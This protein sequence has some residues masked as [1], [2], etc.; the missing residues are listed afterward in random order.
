MVEIDNM[1]FGYNGELLFND[2]SLR[3]EKGNIYGLLGLNG[4][5]KTSL[6]KLISGLI[7]PKEGRIDVMGE[8]P[9]LRRPGWLSRVSVLLEEFNAPNISL[10]GYVSSRSPFYPSFD[11]EQLERFLREFDISGNPILSKLSYGQ[12]KKFLIA[13]GLA[14]GCELL[15]MDE[16]TNGL[17]IPS[18]EIFR[19]LVAESLTEDR[20]FVISTHQIRDVNAL[21]DPLIILHN[22]QILFAHFMAKIME[23]IHMTRTTSPPPS[24]AEGLIYSQAAV[25]GYWAVWS[26]AGGNNSPV[27]L[28]ILFNAVI[29]KSQILAKELSYEQGI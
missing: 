7:F 6:L 19:S 3:L 13:F 1:S 22:G 24:D 12:R 8:E 23:H 14:S 9:R 26:G 11:R 10:Q 16:P 4:V 27:D 5:G 25:G 29:S 15:I 21:I 28:E 20:V 18:K 2:L 17:D